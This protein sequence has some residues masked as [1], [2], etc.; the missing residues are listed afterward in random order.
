MKTN[1][2]T[3]NSEQIYLISYNKTFIKFQG[4]KII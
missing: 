1:S 3:I 2:L 4:L